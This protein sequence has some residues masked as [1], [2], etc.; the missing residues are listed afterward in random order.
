MA[1]AM[2]LLGTSAVQAQEK[3]LPRHEVSVNF[4]GL[5]FGSM[6]FS[7]DKDWDN[8]AGL[9]LGFGM[10]YTYWFNDHVGFR[11][12]LRLNSL[13]HS[14][15]LDNLNIPFSATMSL[16]SLGLPGGSGNTNVSLLGT[17]T[18]KRRNCSVVSDSP[19]SGKASSE[20]MRASISAVSLRLSATVRKS[21]A[22][23]IFAA[24]AVPSGEWQR[25]AIS[26][27]TA[28]KPT[29]DSNVSG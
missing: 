7:G 8:H 19:S 10:N 27:R 29:F 5:G 6:P 18:A 24:A 12:G 25:C 21:R 2:A 20:V 11:T 14:Q 9:S 17:A 26:C 23:R 1:A 3:E 13:T 28:S 4:Q 15:S 22:K 16:S